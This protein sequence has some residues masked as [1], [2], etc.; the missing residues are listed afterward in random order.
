MPDQQRPQSGAVTGENVLQAD[1]K[2]MVRALREIVRRGILTFR[3]LPDPDAKFLRQGRSWQVVHDARE[4][5]GYASVTVRDFQPTALE[6][7]QA[8][9]VLTWLT[10]LSKQDGGEAVKRITAWAMGLPVWRIAQRENVSE[11]T[12]NRR[13]DRSICDI[14]NTFVGTDVDLEIVDEPHKATPFAMSWTPKQS[15]DEAF[16]DL[17]GAREVTVQTVYVYG[18]G[19]MRN[20]KKWRDGGHK[21]EKLVA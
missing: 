20:G 13:I 11:K 15:W 4:A 21:A 7:D 6:I 8:M 2:D 18:H 3:A 14:M 19:L 5:Y 12:V 16:G 9:V 10:W 17:D 1:D